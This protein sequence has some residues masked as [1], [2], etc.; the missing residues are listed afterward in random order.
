VTAFNRYGA[1]TPR[2]YTYS[3]NVPVAPPERRESAAGADV[4]PAAPIKKKIDGRRRKEIP[5]AKIART[6]YMA[7]QG[8]SARE[9]ADATGSTPEKVYGL[10]RRTGIALSPKGQAFTTLPLRIDRAAMQAIEKAALEHDV[11]PLA[12]AGRLLREVADDPELM[13]SLV[14][15]AAHVLSGS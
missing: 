12:L 2:H 8:A 15:D 13:H 4:P 9:I 11:E 3:K 7:G 14:V 6:A 5:A 1:L 10:C